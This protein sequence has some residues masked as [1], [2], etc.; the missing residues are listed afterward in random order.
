LS[1][2]TLYI[3]KQTE[4]E[5]DNY[6]LDCFHDSGTIS[7]LV[8]SNYTILSGRKGMGKT[9]VARYLEKNAALYG[10]DFAFRLSIRNFNIQ[11]F[12]SEKNTL[13]SILYYIVVK[14]VQKMINVG[15]FSDESTKYWKDFLLTNG[16]QQ[17]AD[18]ESFVTTKKARK[19][20]F[21]I[22]A[23][24]SYFFVKGEGA[25]RVDLEN[26]KTRAEIA[27]SPASLYDSLRQSI[28]PDHNVI[29]FIDDI[30]DYL[31]ESNP[32]VL[33]EDLD[34]IKIL[35]LNL[36]TYN[37]N[38]A[39]ESLSLRFVSLVRDDLFEYME[40]SN[41]NKLKTD[42]LRIEWDERAFAG[43][44]IRRMPYFADKLDEALRDPVI[45]LKE[46]FPD[47]IFAEFLKSFSTN[48]FKSNFYAYMAAVSFNRPRDFL[49]FCYALRQRLSPRGPATSENIE[50]AEI[51]Y[52]DYFIQELRDEL[53]VASRIFN[54][55]LTQERINQLVDIL[56]K[57]DD[58]NSSQL[59]TDLAAFV[60]TKTSVGNKKI[61]MLITELWRYGIIGV[62]V[63]PIRSIKPMKTTTPEKI[64][65]L[66]L[67]KYLSDSA[68]FTSEKIK[69]YTFYLHRGLWWFA[70]KRRRKN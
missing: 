42:S 66:I 70:K 6:L 34:I 33:K 46:R 16:L 41:I 51:E 62:S 60:G 12:D 45:S 54:L 64:E 53:F 26:E 52:T 37:L 9:A 7:E 40:G 67:F 19:T 49:Q 44:I 36:Q 17:I 21:S 63:K 47:E 13:D 68:V 10:V 1:M 4:A 50:S 18:Y 23:I 14:A 56:S 43:L 65:K 48:R 15:Y 55:D 27:D 31:D 58:F 61:E 8:N 29:I 20:G 24:A 5:K 11:K 59:K 2:A 3:N 38:F 28:N 22:K 69:E 35:L 39:E 57:K 32:E 25:T 30:S